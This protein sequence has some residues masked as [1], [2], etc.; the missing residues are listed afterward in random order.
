MLHNISWRLFSFFLLGAA[1]YFTYCYR[2]LR[3]VFAALFSLIQLSYR[4]CNVICPSSCVSI[5]LYSTESFPG[6]CNIYHFLCQTCQI[7]G[8][9][10][11]VGEIRLLKTVS[12]VLLELRLNECSPWSAAILFFLKKIRAL[13]FFLKW[14]SNCFYS[15]SIYIGFLGNCYREVC[16]FCIVF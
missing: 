2:S 15:S 9:R 5:L 8:K 10:L 14:H 7:L 16:N 12:F 11:Q 1:V 4:F 6:K 13:I 3:K